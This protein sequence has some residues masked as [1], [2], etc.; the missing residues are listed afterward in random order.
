MQTKWHHGIRQTLAVEFLFVQVFVCVQVALM[1][2]SEALQRAE[3]FCGGSLLSDTW[4]ITAAHCLMEA[5]IK[6]HHFF[7]RVGREKNNTYTSNEGP[8]PKLTVT[9]LST[10]LQVNTM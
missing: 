7:V 5:K 2:H 4:V 6:N 10:N 8:S 1:S 9:R 3:P